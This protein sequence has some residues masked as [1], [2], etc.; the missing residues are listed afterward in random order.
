MAHT[1]SGHD[2]SSVPTLSA[3]SSVDLKTIVPLVADPSTNRLLV[4]LSGGIAGILQTDIFVATAGQTAF[5]ASQNV[6]VTMYV[7]VN[8][9][10]QTP[11]N[12]DPSGYYTVTGGTAT[13]SS[14]QIVGSIIIWCYSTA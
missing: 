8:G 7:S 2:E 13:F 12:L 4:D 14:G 3:L 5:N 9:A 6:A 1:N 10:I 11:Q